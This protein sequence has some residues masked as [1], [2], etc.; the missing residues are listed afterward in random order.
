VEGARAQAGAANAPCGDTNGDGTTNVT[1]A[2]VLLNFLFL[3]GPTPTACAQGQPGGFNA[4]MLAAASGE[5]DPGMPRR[6]DVAW[7]DVTTGMEKPIV[8]V[9]YDVLF[10]NETPPV[11]DEPGDVFVD[12]VRKTIHFTVG[13]DAD[14]KEWVITVPVN[15]GALPTAT[16]LLRS[17]IEDIEFAPF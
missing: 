13:N 11:R 6:V 16:L 14:T 10:P 17:D 5:P 2:L 3:G 7:L 4:I 1:D 9:D 15:G 12:P 8:T